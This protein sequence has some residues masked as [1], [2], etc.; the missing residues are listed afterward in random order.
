MTSVGGWN[1]ESLCGKNPFDLGDSKWQLL[2]PGKDC[3]IGA[4]IEPCDL[5]SIS[6]KNG[7]TE[8]IFGPEINGYVSKTTADYLKKGALIKISGLRR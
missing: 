6:D 5:D 8:I 2:V 4:I 1:L 7:M 3:G